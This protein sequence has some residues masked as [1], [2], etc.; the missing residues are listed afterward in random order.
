[1]PIFRNQRGAASGCANY[2]ANELG[3]PPATEVIA[4]L[5]GAWTDQPILTPCSRR[6]SYDRGGSRYR[7]GTHCR[8]ALTMRAQQLAA[9]GDRRKKRPELLSGQVS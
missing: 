7:T 5:T 4:E 9:V 8:G 1:M 3:L 6:P 2:L